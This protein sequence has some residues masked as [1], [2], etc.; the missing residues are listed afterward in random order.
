MQRYGTHL[1]EGCTIQLNKSIVSTIKHYMTAV[2]KFYK[3]KHLP[4]PWDSLGMTQANNMLKKQ[5]AFEGEPERREPLYDKVLTQ[6]MTLSE[7]SH[8]LSFR[9]DVWIWTHLD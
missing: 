6:M 4:E 9:Q 8:E 1:L 7:A 3:S 2:N 5:K